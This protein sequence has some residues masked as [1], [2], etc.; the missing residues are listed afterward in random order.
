[1]LVRASTKTFVSRFQKNNK[2]KSSLAGSVV[3]RGITVFVHVPNAGH[4]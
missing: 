4:H 3:S 2:K 1:M